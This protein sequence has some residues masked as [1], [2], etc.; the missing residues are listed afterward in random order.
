[1]KRLVG[2]FLKGLLF[3]VP[4]VITI[5]VLYLIFIKIDGLFRIPIPGVGF[6]LIFI[7][8][9]LVGFLTSVFITRHLV[10]MV[11]TLFNRLPFV[12]LLYSAVKDLMNAF[13]GDKKMFDKPVLVTISPDSNIRI[14]GFIT[15]GNLESFGLK[16][17]VAVYVPQA[18]NFAGNLI[19]VPR[20]QITPINKD[21]SE[22]MAFIVSA[23]VSGKN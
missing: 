6:V 11:D 16:E 7:V 14:I 10:K 2:Y 20:E 13:V 8:I 12:K 4:L 21:G 3:V 22:V 9:T 15:R 19:I 17:N 23:G 5:Y 18:Y 1:M